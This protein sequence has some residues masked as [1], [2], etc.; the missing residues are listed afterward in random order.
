MAVMIAGLLWLGFYPQP[1]LNTFEQ[2]MNKLQRQ[3]QLS[4]AAL[5]DG[6][7]GFAVKQ[8]SEIAP[9][10]RGGRGVKSF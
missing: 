10:R 4:T 1:V 7:S 9:P 8:S 6:S 2:A 5:E 3:A